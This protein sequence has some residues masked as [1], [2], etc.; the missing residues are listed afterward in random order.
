[1]PPL[2]GIVPIFKNQTLG[3]SK[4]FYSDY[5]LSICFFPP[6]SI[7]LIFCILVCHRYHS[8]LFPPF[9]SL[10]MSTIKNICCCVPWFINSENVL[11]L[12]NKCLHSIKMQFSSEQ[13]CRIP[14][15][16]FNL[17]FVARNP[18]GFWYRTCRMQR[19][20]HAVILN[21]K[22]WCWLPFTSPSSARLAPSC[23]MTPAS[24]W[25]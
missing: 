4:A 6:F 7:S 8:S 24:P 10:V 3:S 25:H 16:P 14:R 2:P 20:T 19:L 17:Y 18:T 9:G 15:S 5:C 1:M 13:S 21:R 11:L 12:S 22:A 23:G